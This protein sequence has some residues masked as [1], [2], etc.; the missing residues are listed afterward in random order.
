MMNQ[1]ITNCISCYPSTFP[2]A[3]RT[4]Q[5]IVSRGS[6]RLLCLFRFNE[7]LPPAFR[8]CTVEVKEHILD[9]RMPNVFVIEIGFRNNYRCRCFRRDHFLRETL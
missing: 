1:A 2:F 6:D 7:M 3:K 5:S 8:L 4:K 9:E